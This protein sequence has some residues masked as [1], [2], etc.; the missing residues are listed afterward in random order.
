MTGGLPCQPLISARTAR[1]LNNRASAEGRKE[2][3]AFRASKKVANDGGAD[4]VIYA[5][6]NERR[7]RKKERRRRRRTGIENFSD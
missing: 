6:S 7:K 5:A 2:L 3:R 1:I 4:R